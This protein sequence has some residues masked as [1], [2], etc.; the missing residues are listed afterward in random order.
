MA[1]ETELALM[2]DVGV[3]SSRQLALLFSRVCRKV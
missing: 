2:F 1:R 3:G